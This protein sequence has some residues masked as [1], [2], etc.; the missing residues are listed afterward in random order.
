ML[1]HTRNICVLVR[2]KRTHDTTDQSTHTLHKPVGNCPNPNC[3]PPQRKGR[4]RR[5]LLIS[6]STQVRS[7]WEGSSLKSPCQMKI[8]TTNMDSNV[9]FVQ[10]TQMTSD[11]LT[12]ELVCFSSLT[13]LTSK[14]VHAFVHTKLS[15][16]QTLASGARAGVTYCLIRD[17][18]PSPRDDWKNP[19]AI[20]ED[21]NGHFQTWV[22]SSFNSHAAP[23]S[24]D[25]VPDGWS[26]TEQSQREGETRF[27]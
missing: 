26:V 22:C 7:K 4:H 9:P 20:V 2:V 17:T 27:I 12:E 23:T 16:K 5:T 8:H 19:D 3:A 25:T 18:H 21:T 13:R 10:K 1:K 6:L 15:S 11:L 24:S 14:D